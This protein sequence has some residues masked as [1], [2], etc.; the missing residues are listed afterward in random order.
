MAERHSL[1]QLGVRL[2]RIGID[3]SHSRRMHPQTHGKDERLHRTL[4]AEVISRHHLVDIAYAQRQFDAWRHLYNHRRPHEALRIQTPA[5]RYSSSK[6]SF[7]S[8]L[9]PIEYKSGDWVRKVDE[10][11][12]LRFRSHAIRVSKALCGHPLALRANP[13]SEQR[14]AVYFC[15]ACT[16]ARIARLD[17]SERTPRQTELPCEPCLRSKHTP[18]E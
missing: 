3:L 1:T 15:H 12:W 9:P 7:P 13:Q 14:W 4:K 2:I 18:Q 10:G 17:L 11:G 6:R 5:Q 16:H 8:C